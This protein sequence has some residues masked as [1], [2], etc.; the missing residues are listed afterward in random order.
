MKTKV[1]PGINNLVK[2]MGK[3][4][5]E[6]KGIGLI[7]NITGLSAE[8][9]STIDLLHEKGRLVKLFA[10]EHGIRNEFEAGVK[11]E[12][13][14]DEKTG[15]PVISL[16]GENRRPSKAMLEGVDVVVFDIQDVGA[17][18]YTYLYTMAYAMEACA[19]LGLPMLVLDRPNPIGGVK[20]EGGVLDPEFRSF[21]GYFPIT[22]RFG[23]TIGESARMFNEEFGVGCNLTVVPM[24][25]YERSMYYDET[26]LI[27]VVPS[28]N[29]PSLESCI[30]YPG[31]CIFEGTN[32]SEGRGTTKPFQFIG[33][34]WIDPAKL[35]DKA[36]SLGIP[37]V[38]YRPQCFTPTFS[39]HKG[40]FCRGVE[41]HVTDREE[42]NAP[43]AG[44]ALL[45]TI[46]DMYKEFEW[47]PSRLEGQKP[48]ADL[49]SGSDRVRLGKHSLNELLG[50]YDKESGEFARMKAKY[51]LYK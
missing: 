50:I 42:F 51:H 25:G 2:D 15:T 30:I 10:P 1:I 39:K 32:L 34:P 17:R 22:H 13:Y 43:K 29:L 45:Y 44:T 35:A 12:N 26:G 38:F 49:L 8:G 9:K 18:F 20:V 27:W 7:T 11:F 48:F 40:D 31:T 14:A 4:G 41:V 24:T 19:E 21:I 6:G 37:G 28:P 33:A 3:Y 5:L 16:Y 47:L 36:N 23:L 46:R